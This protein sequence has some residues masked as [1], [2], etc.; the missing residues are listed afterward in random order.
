MAEDNL[1][2]LKKDKEEA[3]TYKLK[4]QTKKGD[5]TKMAGIKRKENILYILYKPEIQQFSTD[6][7]LIVV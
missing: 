4:K 1:F 5:C 2:L 3:E 6:A 7:S